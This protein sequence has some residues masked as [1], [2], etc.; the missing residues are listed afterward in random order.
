MEK[1][2]ETLSTYQG[3][4]SLS[5]H[6]VCKNLGSFRRQTGAYGSKENIFERPTL[7]VAQLTGCK[8]SP[9]LRQSHPMGG[10]Y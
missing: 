1:Q 7:I 9:A 8:T 2:I 4:S 10:S 3:V 5:P 6:C